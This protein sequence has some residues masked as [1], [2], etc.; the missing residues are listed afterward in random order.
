MLP[1][2][3][4]LLIGKGWGVLY[5]GLAIASQIYL[6]NMYFS[7]IDSFVLIQP[8]LADKAF[9]VGLVMSFVIAVTV[10]VAVMRYE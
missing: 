7:Q 5:A 6:V 4:F 9:I 1:V 10:F 3:G 2:V 8:Q